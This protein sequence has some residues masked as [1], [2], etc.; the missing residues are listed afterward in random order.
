M[1]PLESIKFLPFGALVLVL[2]SQ[3]QQAANAHIAKLIAWSLG[4]ASRGV[5]PDRGFNDEPF[6]KNSYRFA[7]AGKELAGGWRP[8]SNQREKQRHT[9]F[10]CTLMVSMFIQQKNKFNLCKNFSYRVRACYFSCKADLKARQ[11]MHEFRQYYRCGQPH[12]LFY[13]ISSSFLTLMMWIPKWFLMTFKYNVPLAWGI[14]KPASRLCDS[15]LASVGKN[16]PPSMHGR[17]FGPSVAWPLTRLSHEA[18]LA[19]ERCI[20]PFTAI[21]GFRLETVM[22]D[23]LHNVNL[24]C[25]RDLFASGLRILILKGVWGPLEYWDDTLNRVHMELHRTCA[26]HGPLFIDWFFSLTASHYFQG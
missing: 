2:P 8:A 26:A 4:C 1:K 23:W 13:C 9:I 19:R 25:G 12:G 6:P 7:L 16:T 18:Y 24:G 10:H 11:Y 21:D 5:G 22:Y 20:S 3:V 14:L 15:C 17:A